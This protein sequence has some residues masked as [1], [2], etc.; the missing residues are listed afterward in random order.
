MYNFLFKW[1]KWAIVLCVVGFT[2]M[3]SVKGSGPLTTH[4]LNTGDGVPAAR[5]AL[6][7]HRLDSRMTIWSLVT[8]G[9]VDACQFWMFLNVWTSR[10]AWRSYTGSTNDVSLGRD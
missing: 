3:G 7:L 1:I 4:V 10:P 6:S 9:W 8:V 2:A 5:M